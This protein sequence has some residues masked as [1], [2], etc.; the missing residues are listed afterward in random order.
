MD[1]EL[2]QKVMLYGGGALLVLALSVAGML[3]NRVRTSESSLHSV[4]QELVQARQSSLT[5]TAKV[6]QLERSLETSKRDFKERLLARDKDGKA[7]LDGK[8]KP[9]FENRSGSESSSSE[10][11]KQF[12]SLQTK[13]ETLSIS[14]SA[15][16]AQYDELKKKMSRP[17]LSPWEFS[18]DYEPRLF[19]L[20]DYVNADWMGGAAYHLPLLGLDA[21]IRAGIG[22][23]P[24][25]FARDPSTAW[26]A[27]IG[28]SVRP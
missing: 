12:S 8:G 17:G 10:T 23:S 25:D 21:G 11:L 15:K 4:T 2:K 16:S 5:A 3:F 27:R 9:I 22:A 13:V 6:E 28:L 24:A 26:K 1:A 7:L 20:A 18:L 19:A 14:L